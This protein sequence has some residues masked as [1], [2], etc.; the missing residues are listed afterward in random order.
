MAAP[1]WSGRTGSRPTAATAEGRGPPSSAP[2]P[3]GREPGR[4][5][6]PTKWSSCGSWPTRC[7]WRG[8]APRQGEPDGRTRHAAAGQRT[9]HALMEHVPE[10][11]TIADGPDARIRMVSRHGEELLGG[12]H[13][14]LTA[15]DVAGRWRVYR[16]DGETPLD[17]GDL[18]ILMGIRSARPCGM[19]KS[20]QRNERGSKLVLLCNAAPIRDDAGGIRAPS[21]SGATSP[22]GR[23][24]SSPCG[25][26]RSGFR[27]GLRTVLPRASCSAISGGRILTST[28]D[29][30]VSRDTRTGADR[31]RHPRPHA[32]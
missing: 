14:G 32:P 26:A 30:A 31:A 19:R 12:A 22:N 11:I 13:A 29:S 27:S 5:S 16:E 9:L 1:T 3:S 18:P 25:R 10:G 7:P 17:D 2:C 28:R 21:P 6:R 4:A 24:W 15:G 23:G 20:F 8:E